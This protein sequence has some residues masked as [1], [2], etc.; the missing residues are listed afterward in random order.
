MSKEGRERHGMEVVGAMDELVIYD[1][2]ILYDSAK[3]V[4]SVRGQYFYS[5]TSL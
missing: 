4:H 3:Q 2:F 1:T 5:V